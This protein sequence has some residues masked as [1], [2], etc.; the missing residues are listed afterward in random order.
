MHSLE[1]FFH[2]GNKGSSHQQVPG[3]EQLR[4]DKCAFNNLVSRSPW[5]FCLLFSLL[6]FS[7]V[8]FQS[9]WRKLLSTFR[10]CNLSMR[11]FVFNIKDILN[12]LRTFRKNIHCNIMVPSS[13]V[14]PA[15][16]EE[17]PSW[18][19]QPEVLPGIENVVPLKSYIQAHPSVVWSFFTFSASFSCFCL[20]LLIVLVGI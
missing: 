18:G 8:P 16:E 3:N 6:V 12:D 11:C 2:I 1:A 7:N 5:C 4:M 9:V 14:T 13:L 10:T 15:L 17:S 19:F 20:C